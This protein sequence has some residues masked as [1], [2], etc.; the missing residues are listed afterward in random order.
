MTYH[1]LRLKLR[2]I[3]AAENAVAPQW[4]KVG[5]LS[6]SLKGQLRHELELDEIPEAVFHFLDDFDIR[7]RDAAYASKQHCDLQPF[8]DGGSD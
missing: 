5:E 8:L 2:E 6:L 3:I 1:D 7:E 4:P